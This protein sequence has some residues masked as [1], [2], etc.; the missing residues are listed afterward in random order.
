M[1]ST[2]KQKILLV[3]DDVNIREMYKMKLELSGY[4]I[5]TAEDG[6]M[7]VDLIK[8]EN[9]DLALLDIL[10]PKKDGFEV[11]KEIKDSKNKKIKSIPVIMLSNLSNKEDI[12]EAKRLGAVDYFVKAKISP[13]E[14]VEKV[15]EFF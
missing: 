3:E 8:K 1:N 14:I 12:S 10:L 15:N 2:Q 11:L 4:N 6:K 9:P 5:I 13:G 7:A